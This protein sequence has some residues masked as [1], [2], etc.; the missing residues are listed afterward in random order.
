MTFKL[1]F[2]CAQVSSEELFSFNSALKMFYLAPPPRPI[3][4]FVHSLIDAKH[5]KHTCFFYHPHFCVI[6]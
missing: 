3:S 6:A 1:S 5:I 4:L 2:K